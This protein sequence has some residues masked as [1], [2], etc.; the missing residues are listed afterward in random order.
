MTF[1]QSF[2]INEEPEKWG[3]HYQGGE[4][5]SGNTEPPTSEE[6]LRGGMEGDCSLGC[7]W[8]RGKGRQP[9]L[10]GSGG[11]WKPGSV[12]ESSCDGCRFTKKEIH[13]RKL[14]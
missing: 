4:V 7:G 9:A 5:E 11:D 8:V 13:S 1:W 14:H 3:S 12:Q 10:A 2:A 6:S